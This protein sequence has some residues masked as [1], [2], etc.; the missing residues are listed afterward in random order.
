MMIM[1]HQ[2]TSPGVY[3]SCFHMF[4]TVVLRW[5]AARGVAHGLRMRHASHCVLDVLQSHLPGYCIQSESENIGAL[6]Q[7]R[8]TS[9]MNTAIL[10]M[11]L[12]ACRCD[13]HGCRL[14]MSLLQMSSKAPKSAT[15]LSLP[16]RTVCT[17]C[18]IGRMNLDEFGC[19]CV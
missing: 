10:D 17:V 5:R 8:I 6:R 3:P 19:G 1:S 4:D 9:V 16:C 7:K 2:V 14:R 15:P 11:I 13:Y 12:S 18:I